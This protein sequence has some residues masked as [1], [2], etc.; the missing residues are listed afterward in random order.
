MLSMTRLR[1][2]TTI[3][4]AIVVCGTVRQLRPEGDQIRLVLVDREGHKTPVG[5]LPPT[6]FAPRISP[7]GKQ[8][9]W[10]TVDGTVWVSDLSNLKAARRLASANYPMWSADGRQI[11]YTS[12]LLGEETLYIRRS[13]GTGASE[14]ISAGRAPESWSA[15]NQMLSFI[16][17]GGNYSIWTYSLND[18]KAKKAAALIDTP[19]VDQHSS[20]FSPDGKWIAYASSENGPFEVFVR[21]FPL[22]GAKFRISPRGG[23]HPLWSPD[24][25][26]IFFDNDGRLF[27]VGVQTAGSFSAAPPVA[28]PVSGFIQ[29]SARRQ[30]DLMPDGKQFLMMFPN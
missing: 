24:G 12:T 15:P 8:L 9:T 25:K 28:L 6:T 17:L 30:Y 10:D 1:V 29:G 27:A 22:S 16:K 3:A 19:G 5:F 13:D 11:V 4:A 18:K 23:G 26:E 14:W 20:R 2:A 7:D 21:P